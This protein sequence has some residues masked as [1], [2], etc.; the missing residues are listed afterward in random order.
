MQIRPGV[1]H[2]SFIDDCAKQIDRCVIDE[3]ADCVH[4]CGEPV[5]AILEDETE[6]FDGFDGAGQEGRIITLYW[7]KSDQFNARSG[8]PVVFK[9]QTYKIKKGYP[10][11]TRDCWLMAEL[12]TCGT[13]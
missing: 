8:D 5:K 11:D 12:S 13:C 7:L 4:I 3:L 10:I 9:G 1:A 6:K 2:Q